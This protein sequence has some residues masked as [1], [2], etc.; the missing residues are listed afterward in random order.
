MR[1]APIEALADGIRSSTRPVAVL[2]GAGTSHSAGVAT[3]EE[4]LRRIAAECGEDAGSDPVAWYVG[5]FG[6]FPDYFAMVQGG[7]GGGL[8]LPPRLF[9]GGGPTPAH[10]V[11]A[12]MA[13][14]GMAGPFLTTNFDRLLERA[15]AEAGV[16][17]R[18]V[19]DIEGMAGAELETGLVV[20]LHGDYRDL[21]IRDSAS[22][23]HTYHPVV[24][25]LLDRVL[26]AAPLLVCGWSASW[27]VP[28][29]EALLRTAGRQPTYWL[30]CGEPTGRALAIIAG[31]DALVARVS[32]SDAGL[33]ALRD[34][35]TRRE[36]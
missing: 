31:R 18:A 27:D 14:W 23:L 29:G 15:L 35:L 17:V 25:A 30:Q 1:T 36:R 3:G 7:A 6:R 5:R 34:S 12:E 16:V 9:E 32:G 19:Y 8:S 21:A 10:R 28:L 22:A 26:S 2:A 11:L 24:D 4:L 13:G 33:R 20:K